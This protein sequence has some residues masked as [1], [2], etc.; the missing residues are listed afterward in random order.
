MSGSAR[1][2]QSALLPLEGIQRSVG[3]GLSGR[4]QR[5]PDQQRGQGGNQT[6]H[7]NSSLQVEVLTAHP[8][9]AFFMPGSAWPRA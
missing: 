1:D 2:I 7:A 8:V 6:F 9:R 3:S 5:C 4:G